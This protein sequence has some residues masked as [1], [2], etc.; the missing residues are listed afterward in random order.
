MGHQ[1]FRSIRRLVERLAS[2][3]PLVLVFEDLHWADQSSTELIEHLL[4]LVHTAPLMVC[5]VGRPERDSPATRLRQLTR[6]QYAGRYREIVLTALPPDASAALLENI[7]AEDQLPPQ[8]KALILAK[9]DGNPFF[10][11]EVLRSLIAA[12]TLTWDRAAATWRVTGAVER[13]AIPDT[14][15]GVIMARVDRLEDDVKD[16]LKVASVIGHSFPYRVLRAVC[17]AAPNLDGQ[18]A[19]LQQR[20]LIREKRRVPELE[21]V[22]KHALVQEATYESILLERRRA[23]HRQIATCIEQLW[24]ERVDAAYGLLAYHHAQAEDWEQAQSYLFK[25]AD[26]AGAIAADAEALALYRDALRAYERAFGDR[27]TPFE[28][29]VLDRKIG[30]ALLRRGQHDA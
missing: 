22:F 23:L 18:L 9:S 27:W 3:Q 6:A 8:L 20:E 13:L 1:I 21:Y 12:R 30:E 16:V 11:E 14:L 17:A 7:V 28:R 25:A 26:Q 24:G 15:H 10:I 5:G 29:A 2:R 4:A 19:A